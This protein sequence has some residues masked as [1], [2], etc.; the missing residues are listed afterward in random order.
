M[1]DGLAAALASRD[2]KAADQIFDGLDKNGDGHLELEE[3]RSIHDFPAHECCLLPFTASEVRALTPGVRGDLTRVGSQLREY[4]MSRDTWCTQ[5]Q[6]GRLFEALDANNDGKISRQ[7]LRDGLGREAGGKPTLLWMMALKPPPSG[8]GI[9]ADLVN[10][11]GGVNIP[12]AEYRAI[13][14]GQLKAVVAHAQRRCTKE[15][16]LGKRPVPKG[17]TRYEII[18]SNA[19]NLYDVTSHVILPMTYGHK[20]PGG[21][22]KPSYIELIADGPQRP[23][24]FVSH[25]WGEPVKQLVACLA[26]HTRDRKYGASQSKGKEQESGDGDAGRMWVC[27]FANRQWS[28]QGDVAEDPSKSSFHKAIRLSLGTIA[29]IDPESAYFT[30]VWC[31]YEMYVSLTAS[32]DTDGT[33]CWDIAAPSTEVERFTLDIYTAGAERNG[34]PAAASG[35]VDG[36]AA[37]DMEHAA[38]VGDADADKEKQKSALHKMKKERESMFPI[39]RLQHGRAARVQEGKASVDK[40]RQH[41]LNTMAGRGLSA[42]TLDEHEGYERVNR[43]LHGRVQQLVEGGESSVSA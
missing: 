43:M 39:G 26:Q 17:G 15:R 7:E 30:R 13:T 25:F 24:Y 38:S 4:L 3:V 32:I 10:E 36:I 31:C 37:V 5:E 19:I 22:E 11:N 29:I 28:T 12:D 6:V 42:E 35:F 20:L 2:D 18:K 34:R 33:R 23:E 1:E 27:A 9:F 16:W 21:H 41:I 40:D 14:L 8:I